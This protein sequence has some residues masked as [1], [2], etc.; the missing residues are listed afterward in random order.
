MGTRGYAHTPSSWAVIVVAPLLP[1]ARSTFNAHLTI[2]R[3]VNYILDR[4]CFYT[5]I[6]YSCT[7]KL[8]LISHQHLFP[9]SLAIRRTHL[10]YDE[11]G[12]SSEK[13]RNYTLESDSSAMGITR[14]CKG[15]AEGKV[16][17]NLKKKK[18]GSRYFCLLHHFWSR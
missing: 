4:Q 7:R 14:I 9:C 1:L 16:G 8:D 3:Q 10:T 17:V 6:F 13:D 12:Y 2:Q 15:W 18:R 11:K 5:S